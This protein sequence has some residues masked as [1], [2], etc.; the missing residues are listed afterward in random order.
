MTVQQKRQRTT[1]CFNRE[2]NDAPIATKVSTIHTDSDNIVYLNQSEKNT[3]K[4]RFLEIVGH[5][6]VHRGLSF[7]IGEGVRG[8]QGST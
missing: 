4:Y 8:I 5:F 7:F 1:N 2:M 3:E 6:T